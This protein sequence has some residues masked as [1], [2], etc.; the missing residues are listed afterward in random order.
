[1]NKIKTKNIDLAIVTNESFPIGMAATNRLL[2]YTTEI[3]KR[4]NVK[5]LI[6]KPTE[7][8]SAIKNKLAEG[9]HLGIKYKYIHG[10]TIWPKGKSKFHKLI[11][12][13]KGYFLLFQNIRKIKPKSILLISNSLS[14]IWV[15]WF[16]SKIFGFRYFQEKSEKPPVLKRKIFFCIKN[17]TSYHTDYLMV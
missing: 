13:L 10:T 1:M 16:Y 2:S 12:I 7:Y 3:A 4:K 14:M 15:L 8:K 6:A 17:S 11:I 9:E 5:V